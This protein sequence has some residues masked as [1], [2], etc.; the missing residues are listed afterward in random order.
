M[1]EPKVSTPPP[2]MA[3]GRRE[4]EPG[5]AYLGTDFARRR[6]SAPRRFRLWI[7]RHLS[8][9]RTAQAATDLRLNGRSS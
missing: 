3:T 6:I 7:R 2:Q 5:R 9:R 1:R 4:W 8:R